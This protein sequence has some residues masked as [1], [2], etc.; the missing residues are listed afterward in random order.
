MK[1]ITYL[2]ILV[3]FQFYGQ[4]LIFTP[5]DKL[6]EYNEFPSESYGLATTYPSSFSLEKYVPPVLNQKGGTCVGYN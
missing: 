5:A 1:K 4:G 2:L 6:S 3:S